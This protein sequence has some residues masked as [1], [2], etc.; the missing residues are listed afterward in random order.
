MIKQTIHPNYTKGNLPQ[1]LHNDIAILALARS[2]NFTLYIRPICLPDLNLHLMYDDLE[3]EKVAVTGW[4]KTDQ[5]GEN[6]DETKMSMLLPIVH[7]KNIQLFE[8]LFIVRRAVS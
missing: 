3:Y 6:F 2:V 8:K 1:Y 4:G 5:K 7:C